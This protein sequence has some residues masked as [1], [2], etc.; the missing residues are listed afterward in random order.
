[1]SSIKTKISV[2]LLLLV[3]SIFG[4][5]GAIEYSKV[6]QNLYNELENTGQ[7]TVSRLVENLELPLWEMDERWIN[8]IITTEMMDDYLQAVIV[9]GADNLIVKQGR[10]ENWKISKQETEEIAAGYIFKQGDVFHRIQKIGQVEIY[11]ST[12]FIEEKL[13]IKQITIIT[14]MVVLSLVLFVFVELMIRKIVIKPLSNLVWATKEISKGHY[15]T[16]LSIKKKDEIGRLAGDFNTMR[17][18]IKL[19]ENERDKALSTVK[20]A[21]DE[22]SNLNESLENNVKQRTKELEES[23]HHL[24][25]L[26]V[27]FE[28]SKDKA[29]LANR[30]KSV[31][32]ANM[33]HEL[34]TPMNAVLGF[35]RLMRDDPL[36][37]SSQKESLDIINKSG[38]HLLNLI[39]DVL[40]M[41]KIESG[42]VTLENAP[43]DLGVLI[44]DI[45]DMMHER[46]EKK[47]LIL[48]FDQSSSF[49]RYIDSDSAKIRQILV[50][51]LSNSIK[52]T[53]SGKVVL[54]LNTLEQCDET[55]ILLSFEVEDTGRGI[56]EDELVSI[57]SS[58]MQVGEQAKQE[59]TGLG[60]AITQQYVSLMKGEVSVKSELGIGST[61]QVKVPVKKVAEEQILSIQPKSTHKVIGIAPG[62]ENYRI[63]I[64]EDQFENRLLLKRLLESV[65]FDVRE[66]ENGLQGVE[67]FRNWKPDFIWM[68]RRMPVM[69][70]IESIER[71]RALPGGDVVNIVAVTASVFDQ[72]RKILLKAGASEIVNKPYRDE[73]IFSCMEKYLGVQYIYDEAEGIKNDAEYIK[74]D[75]QQI[76]KI[77]QKLLTNLTNAATSLDVEESLVIISKIK[78]IDHEL[79]DNLQQLVEVFNFQTLLEKINAH[80]H[81]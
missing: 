39:N 62:Q 80:I 2:Y 73:E 17:E 21:K 56:A 41:A 44:R 63:L 23:N 7:R 12:R 72:E 79:A 57:F 74:F 32:L 19:R 24:Q 36:V 14:K 54:R 61:F 30:A 69:D 77:P 60:L 38:H 15:D 27:E 25:N 43:F 68:D 4:I 51:L 9:K 76:H 40:D 70:G 55:N 10:D 65:G 6:K 28:K 8:K 66:A 11:L 42:R 20:K 78:A 3:I 26:S 71:I 46:A 58:F 47:Q 81:I 49:P 22:L 64:V 33:S 13:Q 52:C 31:F 18:Q 59:G 1:M 67:Q 50:N 45:I 37:T 34:R 53:E 75:E 35:S 29:E 16:R 5:Q 48:E